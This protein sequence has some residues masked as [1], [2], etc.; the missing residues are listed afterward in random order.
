MT[1]NSSF[2]CKLITTFLREGLQLSICEPT[3]NEKRDCKSSLYC[4][5]RFY[6]R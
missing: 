3:A 2:E 4:K 1:L 6:Q 5:C